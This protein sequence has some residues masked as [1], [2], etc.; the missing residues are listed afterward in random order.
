MSA[1]L[2]A[3]VLSE[4]RDDW[5]PLITV[6]RAAR[7]GASDSD[8]VIKQRVLETIREMAVRGEVS[9]G[10]T[11]PGGTGFE[12][13]AT[14]ID[15]SIRRIADSYLQSESEFDWAFT[16]WLELTER[17]RAAVVPFDPSE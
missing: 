4:G 7:E 11:P 5:V 17:G 16:C 13:W 2:R 12:R 15:E 10:W 3:T 9:I 6:D 8:R 1:D 14:S